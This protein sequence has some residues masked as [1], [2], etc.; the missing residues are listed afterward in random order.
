MARSL[1]YVFYVILY[2]AKSGLQMHEDK[3]PF[4]SLLLGR[5][6][7]VFFFF[8]LGDACSLGWGMYW[9]RESGVIWSTFYIRL[10]VSLLRKG[11]T[12]HKKDTIIK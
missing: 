1:Q 8:H 11:M 6:C 3:F 12:T 2:Q 7:L 10:R 5:K 9:L 4:I